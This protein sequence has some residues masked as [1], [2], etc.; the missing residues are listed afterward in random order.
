MK[1]Y[2]NTMVMSMGFRT[3]L[4]FFNCTSDFLIKVVHLTLLFII[5][6]LHSERA[7]FAYVNC[8]QT[9]QFTFYIECI[10]ILSDYKE[11]RIHVNTK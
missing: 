8:P 10:I 5:D 4:W 11:C 3:C 6:L 1:S 2:E 7:C 9:F